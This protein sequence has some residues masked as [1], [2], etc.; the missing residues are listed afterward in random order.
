MRREGQSVCAGKRADGE[1]VWGVFV[2]VCVVC[3]C[4]LTI[5]SSLIDCSD[6][7]AEPRLNVKGKHQPSH[8]II[9]HMIII[10]MII[11]SYDHIIILSYYHII[12]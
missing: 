7:D 10:Y 6:Q 4:K 12:I 2:R 8:M 3:A 9:T 11:L 5:C 1:C